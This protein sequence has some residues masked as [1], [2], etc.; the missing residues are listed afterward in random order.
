MANNDAQ[1][2]K[3]YVTVTSGTTI[4]DLGAGGENLAGDDYPENI[5]A[6]ALTFI[7]ADAGAGTTATISHGNDAT[8]AGGVLTAIT[9]AAQC[10]GQFIVVRDADVITDDEIASVDDAGLVTID[11]AA[12]VSTGIGYVGGKRFVQITFDTPPAAIVGTIEHNRRNFNIVT[13]GDGANP[14]T[15]N[16]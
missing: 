9:D 11:A 1:S 10:P 16:P 12:A 3:R 15:T 14:V 8:V 13:V 6:Q 7:C 5:A 4:I 2:T